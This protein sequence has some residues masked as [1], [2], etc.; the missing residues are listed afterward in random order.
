MGKCNNCKH[1][2]TEFEKGTNSI[3][4]MTLLVEKTNSVLGSMYGIC[5]NGN[6]DT[7]VKWWKN[8]IGVPSSQ[9]PEVP[10]YESTEHTKRLDEMIDLA[11]DILTSLKKDKS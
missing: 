8:S 11:D 7:F 5:E 1:G 9:N 6:Q 2:K 4:G 10:C 3:D